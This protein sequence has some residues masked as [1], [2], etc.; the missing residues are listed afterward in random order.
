MMSLVNTK[1]FALLAWA[2]INAALVLLIGA[3]LG[4]GT[5][6]ARPM[7]VP[8]LHQ[9]APIEIVLPP[10]YRLPPLEKT[11][12]GTVERS[13]FVPT[14][15]KAPPPP[16]PT[17]TM[18][19][20]QFQLLGTTITDEFKI[21]MVKEVSS[22]KVREVYQGYTIN[23]LQLELVEAD[24]VVFSQ[25]DDKEEIRLKIQ[26]SPKP[27]VAPP[28]QGNQPA[29][30]QA[31]QAAQ[32][33]LQRPSQRPQAARWANKQDASA[34]RVERREAIPPPPQ[35]PQTMEERK[36]NPLMKDFYKK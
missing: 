33:A 18:Q 32:A 30:P 10:D 24:R 3:E 12:A 31:A 16:P 29:Q 20:G 17:L 22:G 11:Y 13:L 8:E 14:R 1:R 4:W 15:R 35:L 2:V 34:G 25:Y 5:K 27:V 7:P 26:P 21:A 9:A 28:P 19:K 23:G 6:L 36:N